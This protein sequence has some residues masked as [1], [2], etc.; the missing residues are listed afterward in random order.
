LNDLE[1]DYTQKAVNLGTFLVCTSHLRLHSL[2]ESAR[3]LECAGNDEDAREE[4][5]EMRMVGRERIRAVFSVVLRY[6]L[7]D[8]EDECDQ[9]I[10]KYLGPC[11]LVV[12]R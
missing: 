6:N 10:L 7:D 8:R 3:G 11:T 12:V 9:W 4:K 5:P 1:K 2:R